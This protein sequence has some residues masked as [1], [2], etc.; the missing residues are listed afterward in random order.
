M[1]SGAILLVGIAGVMSGI[2]T[3]NNLYQHQRNLT[4]ALHLCEAFMEELILQTPTDPDVA[5]GDYAAHGPVYF[6]KVGAE[7]GAPSWFEVRWRVVGDTP[8]SGMKRVTVR[9]QW[10]E[11]GQTKSFSLTTD[12]T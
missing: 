5:V 4:Y 8:I 1:I 6:D 7:V 10:S 2:K 12:R 9:V 11:R 3:A